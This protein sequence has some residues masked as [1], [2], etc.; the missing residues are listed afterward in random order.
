MAKPEGVL[1]SYAAAGQFRRNL[2][3]SGFEVNKLHGAPGKREM[4]RALKKVNGN[5]LL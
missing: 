4:T 1:V 5:I 3:A 2:K